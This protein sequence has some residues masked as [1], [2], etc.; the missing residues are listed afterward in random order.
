MVGETGRKY[1]DHPAQTGWPFG[2]KRS[3]LLSS[4]SNP[5]ALND[6]EIL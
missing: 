4:L 5:A 2:L 1:F 6:R 3:H